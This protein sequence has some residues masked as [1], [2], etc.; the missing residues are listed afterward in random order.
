MGTPNP[1]TFPAPFRPVLDDLFLPRQNGTGPQANP[2]AGQPNSKPGK[3]QH[4]RPVSGRAACA[5]ELH[6]SVCQVAR[7]LLLTGT[8]PFAAAGSSRR[9]NAVPCPGPRCSSSSSTNVKP[10]LGPLALS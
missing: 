6:Q 1:Y 5:L 7:L 2:A 9:A 10:A 4:S 8:P 3:H